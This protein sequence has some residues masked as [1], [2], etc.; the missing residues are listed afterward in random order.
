[1]KTMLL[2]GMACLAVLAISCNKSSHSTNEK[3]VADIQ[4]TAKP[5]SGSKSEDSK[6]A[7][8]SDA[9]EESNGLLSNDPSPAPPPPPQQVPGKTNSQSP[10]A[11]PVPM[12]W[13]KKIVRNAEMTMQVKDL[14]TASQQIKSAMQ[15]NGG[16]VETSNEQQL[17]NEIRV[18]MTIKVPRERFDDLVDRLQS[19][20]DSLLQKQI[21]SEDLTEEYVDT[22]ARIRAK[23]KVRERYYDF[24]KRAANIKEVLA[25]ETD[26]RELDEEI[27][28]ATG[29]TNY[30]NHQSALSSIHLI[31]FQT[32]D[33]TTVPQHNPGFV[34]LVA[35]NFSKGLSFLKEIVLILIALWPLALLVL[36][37]VWLF[38]RQKKASAGLVPAE[39]KQ[40]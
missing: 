27:E 24:L 2:A 12:D 16:F 35:E 14:R 15:L 28:S 4:R 7:L 6:K 30:I 22:K 25:V 20:S 36:F 31:Y 5:P 21:T 34:S 38:R 13:E 9:L 37:F 29:R 32:L 26:L 33:V 10:P 39:V 1:M 8:L 23:E 19:S 3:A 40:G 17:S 18:D 11:I